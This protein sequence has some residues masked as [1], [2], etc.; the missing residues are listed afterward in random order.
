MDPE[1]SQFTASQVPMGGCGEL[2]ALL[3]SLG[4][5]S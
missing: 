2:H 1:F 5:L 3:F 4:A